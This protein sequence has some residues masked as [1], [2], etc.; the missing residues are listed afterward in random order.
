[1]SRDS[2]TSVRGVTAFYCCKPCRE[3]GTT[4]LPVGQCAVTSWYAAMKNGYAGWASCPDNSFLQGVY[5]GGCNSLTC[6]EQVKCCFLEGSAG[7]T[8][9]KNTNSGLQNVGWMRARKNAFISGLKKE[10]GSELTS[11]STAKNCRFFAY[12]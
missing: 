3:D 1:M 12:P 10:Q 8:K 7:A 11:I 2:Y 4:A 9:C 6:V 5:K